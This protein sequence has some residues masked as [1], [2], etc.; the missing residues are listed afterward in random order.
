MPFHGKKEMRRAPSAFA[1][2]IRV[3][4]KKK[5]YFFGENVQRVAVHLRNGLLITA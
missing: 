3:L 2:N 4:F 5:P 1:K